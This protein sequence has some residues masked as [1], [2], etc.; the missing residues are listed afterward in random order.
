MTWSIDALSLTFF[1]FHTHLSRDVR[2]RMDFV[3]RGRGW[4]NLVSNLE[5]WKIKLGISCPEKGRDG[6]G[7]RRSERGKR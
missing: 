5:G 4:L 7:E 3:E 1:L 2:R 6:I